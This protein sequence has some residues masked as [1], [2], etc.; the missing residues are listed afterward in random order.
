VLLFG[1]VTALLAVFALASIL[2]LVVSANGYWMLQ[3]A[4]NLIWLAAAAVW[5]VLMLRAWRGETWRLP[6][7]AGL[8]DRIALADVENGA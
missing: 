7:V 1:A 8:A 3:A 5:L 4:S 6:L 2:A